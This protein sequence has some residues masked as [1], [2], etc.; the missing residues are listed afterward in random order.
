MWYVSVCVMQH[1]GVSSTFCSVLHTL[2]YSCP[3]G[4]L[5]EVTGD[6]FWAPS[7]PSSR[8]DTGSLPV[9]CSLHW[10]ACEESPVS[11]SHLTMAVLSWQRHAAAR[12]PSPL[13][14]VFR[15]WTGG[16]MRFPGQPV[17]VGMFLKQNKCM[18]PPMALLRFSCL[19]SK[20]LAHRAFSPALHIINVISK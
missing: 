19:Y 2:T 10:L 17:P 5:V 9:L 6:E 13:T 3:W 7:S 12:C 1:H 8:F 11:T 20:G 14:P 18:I 15:R 16:S 4:V